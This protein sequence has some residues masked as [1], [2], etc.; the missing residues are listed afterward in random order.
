MPDQLESALVLSLRSPLKWQSALETSS[1]GTLTPLNPDATFDPLTYQ[2]RD[3][4]L[5][6]R[7]LIV[8][9]AVVDTALEVANV[10]HYLPDHP[11]L[12]G[13]TVPTL[14]LATSEITS[15]GTNLSM[16]RHVKN[17]SIPWDAARYADADLYGRDTLLYE[18]LARACQT[19]IDPPIL[20]AD[21]NSVVVA[22]GGSL[23]WSLAEA[24]STPADVNAALPL[25]RDLFK[26]PDQFLADRDNQLAAYVSRLSQ[27]LKN[28][29]EYA[30]RL[31]VSVDGVSER[32]PE[33][34]VL[35]ED[36]GSTRTWKA[37]PA[38]SDRNMF[39]YDS[40]NKTLQWVREQVD[41]VHVPQLYA[42]T[43]PGIEIGQTITTLPQ[44]PENK[45]AQFWRQKA[46]QVEPEGPS[47]TDT[48]AYLE[49]TDSNVTI[50]GVMQVDAASLTV[51]NTSVTFQM[52]GTVPAGNTRLAVLIE[53]KSQVEIIGGQNMSD[54]TGTLGGASYAISV[55]SG[56]IAPATSY[57]VEGGDGI[58]YNSVS[59]APNA[60]FTGFTGVT[61][62]TQVNGAF[63]SAV[64]QYNLAFNLPLPTGAWKFKFDY[65][66]ISGT[67]TTG[68]GVKAT[69]VATGQDALEI[70]QDT[71]PLPWTGINGDTLTST[72]V[73]FNVVNTDP[74]GLNLYWTYGDGQFHVRK[75]YLRN[76]TQTTGSYS[77]I[78]TVGTLT[79]T[80]VS[81]LNNLPE[82]MLF[83]GS[84]SADQI[85]PP[86]SINYSAASSLPLLFKQVQMQSLGTYTS[87]PVA[88]R[89]Q[90]WRQECLD[91]T[92]RVV[93]AGYNATIQAFTAA[94]SVIPSF[95]DSGSGWSAEATDAWM[96]FVEVKNP[97]LREV[98][99]VGT[100]DIVVGR[101]YEV[102][103][104]PVVYGGTV[105]GSGDKFYGVYSS[106]SD[107]TGEVMQVGALMKSKPGHVGRPA[108][109]PAG[110]YLE[111]TGSVRASLDTTLSVPEFVSCQP[112]MID[113][114]F[115]VAQE[116]FWM[117]EFV[118]NITV[119]TPTTGTTAEPPLPPVPGVDIWDALV[120]NAPTIYPSAPTPGTSLYA[121]NAGIFDISSTCPAYPGGSGGGQGI[122]C[123]GQF[124]YTG[125]AAPSHLHF[126]VS[127]ASFP[128]FVTNYSLG[129]ITVTVDSV[130]LFSTGG[131]VDNA[132]IYDYDFT[133]PSSVGA[134]IEVY[135]G[136]MFV[137][138]SGGVNPDTFT[139]NGTFY[140]P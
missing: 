98:P 12:Q 135:T 118:Q 130:P 126:V 96:G 69:Y 95:R 79:Y 4:E 15:T 55:A 71:T 26:K 46:G 106:G 122:E 84:Y 8:G 97:R 115:Y 59:Y 29:F 21:P 7:D 109:V 62:Y 72:E 91:R 53:P 38:L 74:F 2:A 44:V 43:I 89:F 66:N 6:Y 56:G 45:D 136:M 131:D 124:L 75:I 137:V 30:L 133:I 47:I 64:R 113:Q 18:V 20:P 24:T 63:P 104:G 110:L 86:V 112:W 36:D 61:T 13:P 92:E 107:Y 48:P 120:W 129:P 111:S 14:P 102:T 100:S 127:P 134:L 5:Q 114:G 85:N 49:R 37:E 94:G 65:G 101:Q 90:G 105:Y 50:G 1:S 54:T 42:L 34:Y 70:L 77:M 108:L 123:T 128:A 31:Y 60:V 19:F 80:N 22:S 81:G 67:N 57:V 16:V 140:N 117:P 87:T 17:V 25:N 78:A 33:V 88:S 51:P 93:Q 41:E 99:D 58:V 40:S 83:D 9:A 32:E 27:V 39:V 82:V 132:G 68:F 138:G 121:L 76:V 52:T 73:D 35:T 119:V 28:P 139:W 125:P 116:E 23:A 10:W 103:T 11:I 3:R